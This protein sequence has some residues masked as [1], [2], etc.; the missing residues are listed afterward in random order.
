MINSVGKC[1]FL[2]VFICFWIKTLGVYFL[3][4]NLRFCSY[5]IF[6]CSNE[7]F[8]LYSSRHKML[9]APKF[10][11]FSQGKGTLHCHGLCGPARNRA[12]SL[13]PAQIFIGPH[14]NTAPGCNQKQEGISFFTD[15]W[16][17]LTVFPQQKQWPI[18]PKV[19]SWVI[20]VT[21][22]T[23]LMKSDTGKLSHLVPLAH[24]TRQSLPL[25]QRP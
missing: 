8:I 13:S 17:T 16:K 11:S 15:T 1:K 24:A 21:I 12:G 4:L 14:L 20:S 9:L 6:N 10:T 19:A 18:F 23:C 7:Y 2:V 5:S 3:M 25:N 22:L